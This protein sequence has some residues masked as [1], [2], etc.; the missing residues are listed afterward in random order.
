MSDKATP[1]FEVLTESIQDV[2]IVGLVYRKW[3]NPMRYIKGK[4]V[5]NKCIAKL[6]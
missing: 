4:L 6:I 5:T 2:E 1:D 3:W